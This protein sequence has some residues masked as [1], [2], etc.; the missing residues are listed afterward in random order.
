MSVDH[1]TANR[2]GL[3]LFAI[4]LWQNWFVIYYNFLL[5]MNG[6]AVTRKKYFSNIINLQAEVNVITKKRKKED[7]YY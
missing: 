1:R 7:Y 6:N 4:V 2:R 3:H 5:R